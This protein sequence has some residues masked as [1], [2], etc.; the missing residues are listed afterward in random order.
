MKKPAWLLVPIFLTFSLNA[1]A[2][3]LDT[4]PTR[5]I[6]PCKVTTSDEKQWNYQDYGFS[7][8]YKDIHGKKQT[9][10]AIS[11]GS[12]K[13]CAKPYVAVSAPIPPGQVE[14][15][16]EKYVGRLGSSISCTNKMTAEL[17]EYKVGDNCKMMV[18]TAKTDTHTQTDACSVNLVCTEAPKMYG[19]LSVKKSEIYKDTTTV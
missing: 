9:V 12:Q 7:I 19:K 13:N 11:S 14:M 8:S 5:F 15:K 4:T 10:A 3:T 17:T 16:L 18:K 2:V 1:F 6:L